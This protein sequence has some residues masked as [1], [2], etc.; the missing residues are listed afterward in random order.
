MCKMPF[1]EIQRQTQTCNIYFAFNLTF[2]F[3]V[4]PQIGTCNFSN[5][6]L[7]FQISR[8]DFCYSFRDISGAKLT[9]ALETERRWERKGG[10]SWSVQRSRFI[11]WQLANEMGLRW[12]HETHWN[13]L[14]WY[15][16]MYL[17]NTFQILWNVKAFY[18][19]LGLFSF[20]FI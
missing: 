18:C 12:C 13:A 7:Q 4:L 3:A 5:L 19:L 20:V 9:C 8:L 10:G 14:D 17:L 16:T 6:S 2:T 1:T 11:G 15:K